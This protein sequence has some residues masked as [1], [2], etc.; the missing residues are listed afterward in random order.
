MGK[1]V[2]LVV[3]VL[4]VVAFALHFSKRGA[5]PATTPTA[6]ASSSAHRR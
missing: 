2:V 3:F 1:I 4:I 5:A 6:G